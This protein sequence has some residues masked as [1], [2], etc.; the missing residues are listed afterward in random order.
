MRRGEGPTVLTVLHMSNFPAP[1][2]ERYDGRAICDSRMYE[3]RVV[4]TEE[5]HVTV[6]C[7]S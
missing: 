4:V 3:G 5:G 7:R 2:R 6:T 1:A